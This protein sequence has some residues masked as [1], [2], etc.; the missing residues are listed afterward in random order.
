MKRKKMS[1]RKS[2]KLF[3]S[4]GQMTNSKNLPKVSRGGIRF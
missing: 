1:N 4:S 3:N 2:K